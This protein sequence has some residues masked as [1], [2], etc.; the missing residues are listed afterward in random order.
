MQKNG[1]IIKNKDKI[2][3]LQK[4]ILAGI[5]ATTSKEL[6]RKAAIGMY[7]DAQAIVKE[8]FNKLEQRGE[9][10]T[11]ETKKLIK[12]L[13]KE[14]QSEKSKIYKQLQKDSKELLNNITNILLTPFTIAKK[15][16]E[17]LSKSNFKPTSK[18]KKNSKKRRRK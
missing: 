2:Q 6:I 10:K 9:L 14:S 3:A 8:L 5:G 1:Y 18:K 16:S 11:K 15:A 12:E 4:A 17:K 13:Q 7:D